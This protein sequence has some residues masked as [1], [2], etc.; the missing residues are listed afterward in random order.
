MNPNLFIVQSASDIAQ[1]TDDY[2]IIEIDGRQ[3]KT[4]RQFYEH[5]AKMMEFP[6]YFGFNL[7]SL[8]ELLNDLDW[9]EDKKIALHFTHTDQLISQERDPKKLASLFNLL[10]AS[11]E[12]WKWVDADDDIDKK[13]LILL[14]DESTRISQL[15]DQEGVAY[16]K[17]GDRAGLNS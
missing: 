16:T 10:D 12:D 1:F 3:S 2:A 7:D 14:V 5:I 11:A 4:L 8:D 9:I 17:V 15:L 13:E 6:D